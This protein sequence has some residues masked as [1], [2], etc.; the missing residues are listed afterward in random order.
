MEKL[1][2]LLTRTVWMLVLSL[3]HAAA[4][5]DSEKGLTD[6]FPEKIP[7]SDIVVALEP[8]VSL[9][10][11]KDS[12]TANMATKARARIQYL[13]P[14]GDGSGRLAIN[15]SRGVLYLVNADGS[16]LT[17][18]LDLRDKGLSFDDSMFVNETG[19]AAVAFHPDFARP[20]TPGYG[21]FYTAFSAKSGT[22][23]TD[24]LSDDAAS[25]DSVIQEW[26]TDN[27][28]AGV[29]NGTS[30][31]VFRIGQFA[32]NHNIGT[33][34]FNP[35]EPGLLYVCLGDGG[36]AFDPRDYG[37]DLSAPHG[38]IIRINP[39]A[40]GE[41]RY[42][43]PADNPF[44]NDE[45]IALEIWAYG[46]RHPQHFSWD[47]DGTLYISDIG[48][49]QVEEVNIGKAGANY[50]WRLREG[51]FKTAF[52]VPG[53]RSGPVF[54]LDGI[55]DGFT[56]PV[57]EYDHDEGKAIGSGYVY[58]G[59]AIPALQGRFV[60]ADIVAG[61]IFAIGTGDLQPGE[62]AP[63]EEI[64]VRINGTLQPLIDVVGYPNTYAPGDRADARLGIDDTGELYVLT[65]GD[66]VVRKIVPAGP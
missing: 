32:P 27:P 19:L 44:I 14:V 59:E 10:R 47:S 29:F 58:E 43:V 40:D 2:P 8:F 53:A 12:S 52:A 55:D 17:K 6:P 4:Q 35:H 41:D 24:Y 22:G 56:Y 28:V 31:E 61:R 9:P 60:F 64:Q 13:V 48:Q 51:T 62:R 33:M 54:P 5:A 11:M 49:D 34:A 30:R 1:K 66:G 25:H 16:G 36:A 18:Y 15:D 65:K 3:V 63:I 26:Q 23:K 38:A 46:L 7:A 21:R 45:A 39:L 37:Q 42:S 57:A 50:G 20:G